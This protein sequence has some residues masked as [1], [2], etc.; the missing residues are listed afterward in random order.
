MFM[1]KAGSFYYSSFV[2]Q[3]TCRFKFFF[4][5]IKKQVFKENHKS[6][7]SFIYAVVYSKT[8][9]S[10]RFSQDYDKFRM[11]FFNRNVL[12]IVN[13][14]QWKNNVSLKICFWGC[15]QYVQLRRPWIPVPPLFLNIK[16][17]SIAL[18][19]VTAFLPVFFTMTAVAKLIG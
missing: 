12:F 1:K 6:D 7:M 11:P 16:W 19:K 18:L 13:S 2:K 15:G 3:A 5:T 9:C 4:G 17:L 14:P 10:I 8:T